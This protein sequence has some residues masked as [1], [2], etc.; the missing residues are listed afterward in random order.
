MPEEFDHF[1]RSVAE[2]NVL[3]GETESGR[4]R[5]AQIKT[6]AIGINMRVFQCGMHR[7]DC[8]GGWPQWILVRSKLDD[9]VGMDTQFARGFLDWFARFVNRK[10]AQLRV[11]QLPNHWRNLDRITF[12]RSPI[13]QSPAILRWAIPFPDFHDDDCDRRIDLPR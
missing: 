12:L 9:R 2:N 10:I 3:R 7:L 8:F 1:V 4:K 5:L 11:R 6:S 13:L